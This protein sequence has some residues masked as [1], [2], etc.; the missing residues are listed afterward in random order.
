MELLIDLLKA[1]VYGIVEGVTEWLPISST[2]HM[3]LLD[4]F[5]KMNVSEDFWNFFLVVIQLGAIM[6]VVLIYFRR[7]WP[8]NFN[9]QKGGLIKMDIMC[10]W[11]KILIACIPA[12]IVGVFLDDILEKYL[13][14]AIVVALMLIIFGVGF[15]IVENRNKNTKARVNSL[16]ELSIKD[17]LIIGVYQLIAAVFPGT[18]RSGATI[19]GALS[20]GISRK[21]AAEFTFFLAIP[22]MFGASL[23]KLIKIGFDFALNEYLILFFGMVT[24]FVVSVLVIRFLMSYIKKHDFKIFG[25]YRIFVGLIVLLYF[26]VLK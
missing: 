21:V 13:Y 26:F 12:A 18:S 6:A 22:V 14:N 15:I 9:K 16:K 3:I 19:L 8:F 2:G 10:L 11:G 4:E 23:L 17:S 5:M 7:I 24:A 25:Y 20:I 1:I